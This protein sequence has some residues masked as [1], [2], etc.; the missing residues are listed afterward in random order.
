MS[1]FSV[2][3]RRCA[4]LPPI[5]VSRD[6]RLPD[7]TR[8]HFPYACC[9]L[10][11]IE[12]YSFDTAT[13]FV[14]LLIFR[15]NCLDSTSDDLI[16]RI[17]EQFID[18]NNKWFLSQ[19]KKFWLLCFKTFR[20][21]PRWVTLIRIYQNRF[22]ARSANE[23]LSKPWLPRDNLIWPIVTQVTPRESTNTANLCQT[24]TSSTFNGD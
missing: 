3:R 8:I 14:F 13:S 12:S 23:Y 20:L 1:L 24:K 4:S 18:C 15:I 21:V 16:S 5:N 9:Q 11:S 10:Y 2:L 7:D 19:G 6:V 22:L 17:K